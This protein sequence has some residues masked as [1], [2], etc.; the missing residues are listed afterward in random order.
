L[1]SAVLRRD[2][3]TRFGPENKFGYFP[4]GS[5]GW[6]A[7]DEDFLIDN[8][9]FDL[10]KV[11][12]SY[13]ILGNDRIG[14]Y[15]FV[16]LLNGE[17]TYFFGGNNREDEYFG[18]ASGPIANPEIKWEKQKTIDIGLDLRFWIIN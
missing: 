14:D 10:I 18:T 13:G 1:F 16:S 9:F 15:R 12:A 8:N 7:S 2:G 5:I 4:S 17:G 11:R 3:S 6:V